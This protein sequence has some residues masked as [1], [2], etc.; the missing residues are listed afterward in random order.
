MAQGVT[1]NLIGGH[2]DGNILQEDVPNGR[3]R[4][5]IDIVLTRQHLNLNTRNLGLENVEL[6]MAKSNGGNQEPDDLERSTCIH[7]GRNW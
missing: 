6:L 7:V 5:S 2:N 3:A 4:P 1:E